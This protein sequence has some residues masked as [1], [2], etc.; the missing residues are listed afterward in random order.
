M[1]IRDM[2][3]WMGSY[4]HGRILTG[5]RL[6]ASLTAP[7]LMREIIRKITWGRA[8]CTLITPGW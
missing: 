7:T 8:D 6:S 4:F 2:Q 5:L 1:D 3:E